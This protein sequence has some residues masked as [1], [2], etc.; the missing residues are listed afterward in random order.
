MSHLATQPLLELLRPPAGWRTDCAILSAYSAEPAV[1]VA[2]LLALAGRDDDAGS[3]SRVALARTMTELNGRVSFVLQ[4]GRLAAPHGTPRV[5]A[6]LDRFVRE[7]PWDEV[8][9]DSAGRS[10]HAKVALAR[11]VPY[12]NPDGPSRWRLWL[13]SRNFTRDTSWDIGLSLETVGSGARGQTLPGID[14]MATRLAAKAGRTRAWRPLA[15]ELAQTR[16][17]VPQGLDVRRVELM[18]PDDGGRGMPQ[19]PA[20]IERLIAVAPFLDGKT[21]GRLGAWGDKK[22]LL[23]SMPELARLNAQTSAPLAGFDLLALPGTPEEGVGPPEEGDATSEAALEARGLHAKLLWAEH[24]RRATLWLGSPNLTQR[25]WQRN[26]EAYA[27]VGVSLRRNPPAARA[28]YDGIEAFRELA[29]PVRPEELGAAVKEDPVEEALER[30]RGQVAARLSGHQ[31]RGMNST[32][33]ET[34]DGPPHPDDTRVALDVARLGGAMRPWPPGAVSVEIPLLDAVETE[35]LSLR[36]SLNGD[37]IS[38]TQRVPF[39]PPLAVVRDTDLLRD[40]LGARGILSWISDEL[41]DAIETD[42]GGPWDAE[43]T[44]GGGSGGRTGT[45]LDLPTVE[46]VLRAWT[47]DPDRLDA[48]DRILRGSGTTRREADDAEARRHL[49]AFARSWRV[50]RRELRGGKGRAA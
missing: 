40:Y 1:L 2:I 6:L 15:A 3:G 41:D 38:W 24:G 14:H 4:R 37:G 18:L 27:E 9:N 29:R 23:S 42:G 22:E 7:V 16:W 35:L 33:V 46:K 19:A 17:D 36:V 47:R 25:A 21:V 48:V 44:G 5:L 10:W 20:D 31:R 28:L 49:D 39:D 26:A 8:A 30:A 50:L 43:R 34:R 13:G 32:I 12:D 45:G 11:T